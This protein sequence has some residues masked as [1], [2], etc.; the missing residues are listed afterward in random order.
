MARNDY[1]L[2]GVELDVKIPPR[3][4]GRLRRT[5]AKVPKGVR[6]QL[7]NDLRRE[8]KPIAARVAAGVPNQAPLSGMAPRWGGAEAE[9]KTFPAGKPGRAI[10]TINVYGEDQKFNRLLAITE[11]AGSRS[12]GISP[13]GKAMI[14]NLEE[15]YPLVGQGGRF[16]WKA[17]LKH[18]PEAVG[19]AI[20]SINRFVD[21]MNSQR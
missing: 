6:R 5:I 15:R 8:L 13:R 4:E 10:A 12:E 11:R 9:V 16:I 2:L 21:K 18:R 1:D 3:T 14:S 17:W 7:S 19:R 20:D